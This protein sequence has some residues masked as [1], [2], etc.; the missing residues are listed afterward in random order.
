MTPPPQ[1]EL[2]CTTVQKQFGF[3]STTANS[4]IVHQLNPPLLQKK[5]ASKI[6]EIMV[7]DG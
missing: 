3:R 2:Q 7:V 4:K 5:F 1:R 6:L